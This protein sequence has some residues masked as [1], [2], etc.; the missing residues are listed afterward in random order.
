[1]ATINYTNGAHLTATPT[2]V[3]LHTVRYEEQPNGA[4]DRVISTVNEQQFNALA[5]DVKKLGGRY[6]ANRFIF[7]IEALDAVKEIAESMWGS[8]VQPAPAADSSSA[9][10]TNAEP[11]LMVKPEPAP[12]PELE[13]FEGLEQSASG[14][15]PWQRGEYHN[16]FQVEMR[17]ENEPGAGIEWAR[18]TTSAHE[19]GRMVLR[20]HPELGSVR[21]L[22][23]RYAVLATVTDPAP[24]C[25]AIRRIEED[26]EPARAAAHILNGCLE[27]LATAVESAAWEDADAHYLS[28]SHHHSA[29]SLA[30][31]VKGI[32]SRPTVLK[33][34]QRDED[35]ADL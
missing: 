29:N 5:V 17:Q 30:A 11:P 22:N 19:V 9:E 27:R 33:W 15:Y 35:E 7:P 3:M 12:E 26:L 13:I 6:N 16:W 32:A 31:L 23:E 2:K 21:V 20:K 34:C 1:M 4:S 24:V 18:R 28:D 14:L 25:D 10:D 8:P